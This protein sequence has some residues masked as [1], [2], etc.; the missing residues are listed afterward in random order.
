MNKILIS[1]ICL[2]SIYKSFALDNGLTTEDINIGENCD[3]GATSTSH[4]LFDYQIK[5]AN[6]SLATGTKQGEALSYVVLEEFDSIP[7]KMSMIGM[8]ENSTKRFIYRISKDA[9]LSAII[10]KRSIKEM[11]KNLEES[12]SMD[13]TLHHITAQKDYKIFDFFN[14]GNSSKVMDMV[15]DHVG[16]NAVDSWGQS[17]LLIAVSNKDIPVISGLLNTRRPS[18]NVNFVKSV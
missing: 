18:V 15:W 2:I 12:I 13:L 11:F 7:M 1:L 9:D 3:I 5:F 4:L 10:I 6:G 17:P 16:V 8:C 14:D